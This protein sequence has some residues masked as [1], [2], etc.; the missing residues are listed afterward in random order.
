MTVLRHGGRP[1]S[2]LLFLAPSSGPGQHGPLILDD[3]GNP[4]WFK[5]T[6]LPAMNFR[7]QTLHGEPV[8]TWWQALPG[9][10]LGRGV[11]VVADASYR[12]IA[13]FPAG[14][15]MPSDL[16]ELLLT[17]RGTALVTSLEVRHR[18]AHGLTLGGVVQELEVPSA[19]VLF[20]WRSLD[21][22]AVAES[23][24]PVG[25]PWDYFHVN[26]IDVDADGNLLVSAR[27]TWAV[28]KVNRRTGAVM[29]RLGGKRSDFALGKDARFAWQHDAR[30]HDDGR[31][32]SIFDNGVTRSRGLVL[33]LDTKSMRASVLREYVHAPP[34]HAHKLGSVQLLG[35]GDVLVG[36]GTDPH[37]TEYA[38]GGAVVLDATLPHGG[39]N[40][41]TLR[42]PWRGRPRDHPVAVR[43]GSTVYASWNGAT[44]VA[45]WKIEPGGTAVP[46]TGFETAL[47]AQA[48]TVV[49]LDA[50]GRALGSYRPR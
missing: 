18:G 25:Y 43:R 38:A 21:H 39:E 5:P 15:G 45:A 48:G 4:V 2:G 11:H 33:A 26:A 35:N 22:V 46:R 9:G 10:G 19:R 49:A 14:H 34:L 16:H 47:P 8:L 41:R 30:S 31:V 28:Y 29:W 37:L 1:A 42:F 50:R 12:E 32:V 44:D 20:E 23:Y 40:Y 24:A 27:N 36:W 3:V 17:D 6:G 13:R 7:A